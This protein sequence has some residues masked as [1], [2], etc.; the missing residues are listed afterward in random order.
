[1]M[2]NCES[3]PEVKCVICSKGLSFCWPVLHQCLVIKHVMPET[4]F[5]SNSDKN[6]FL[7]SF[8]VETVLPEV[9]FYCTWYVFP[10]WL[11]WRHSDVETRPKVCLWDMWDVLKLLC[12]CTVFVFISNVYLVSYNCQKKKKKKV[13]AHDCK[14][15]GNSKAIL[16]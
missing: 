5:S 11:N 9:L 13:K 6:R 10:H 1:M 8:P 12:K 3:H 15:Q 2:L 7:A 16:S 14:S 4:K